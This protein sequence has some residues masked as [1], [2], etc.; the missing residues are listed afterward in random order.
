LS[1]SKSWEFP[2][3]SGYGKEREPVTVRLCDADD[4]SERGLHPAP[5]SRFSDERWWF[6]RDH[7]SQYNRHWNYFTGMSAHDA[8]EAMAEDERLRDG[9]ANGARAWSGVADSENPEQRRR[10]HALAV[11]GLD[12][13]AT[14]GEIKSAFRRLAKENHPD[15]ASDDQQ[16]ADRFRR[17]CTAHQVLTGK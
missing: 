1:Q 3:W 9:F 17:I 10:R 6:C 2:R 11:L 14:H 12:E 13:T 16:A 8:A 5:K 7:A 15:T 4:C